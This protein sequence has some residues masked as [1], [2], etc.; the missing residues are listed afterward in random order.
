MRSTMP[1]GY[2]AFENVSAVALASAMEAEKNN[3]K[4][5]VQ[6]FDTSSTEPMDINN[7]FEIAQTEP[8]GGTDMM[9]ALKRFMDY[10]NNYPGLKDVRQIFILSDFETGYNEETLQE[11]R[12]F[13]K[14]NGLVVTCLHIYGDEVSDEMQHIIDEI[15]DEYYKF[16]NYDASELFSVVY[17]KV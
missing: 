11:F 17:S 4:V 2:T 9:V 14:N 15:C 10:Y 6:Y 12:N 8:G 3:K 5:F 16:N 13:V 7:V 1:N